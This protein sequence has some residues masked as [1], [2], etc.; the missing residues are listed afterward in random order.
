MMKKLTEA[1][2]SML[3]KIYAYTEA[4]KT[5]PQNKDLVEFTGR[6]KSTV[7]ELVK[8]LV[9]SGVVEKKDNMLYL[10]NLSHT[11]LS[12]DLSKQM[13]KTI[14]IL[15]DYEIKKVEINGKVAVSEEIYQKFNLDS[16]EDS[17]RYEKPKLRNTTKSKE[18]VNTQKSKLKRL[19]GAISFS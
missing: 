19:L 18:P 9:E 7:S 14:E 1:E 6:S 13:Q 10:N 3:R 2:I 11:V 16:R 12:D 8:S 5:H 4:N 15:K 17:I